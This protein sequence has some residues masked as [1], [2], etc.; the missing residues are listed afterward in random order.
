MIL[1]ETDNAPFN[2][3][4]QPLPP[5]IAPSQ[6]TDDSKEI[7][8]IIRVFHVAAT[9]LK[10]TPSDAQLTFL[11]SQIET[12]NSLREKHPERESELSQLLFNVLALAQQQESTFVKQTLKSLCLTTFPKF[13]RRTKKQP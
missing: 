1:N 11:R 9:C 12:L 6:K 5:K 10:K 4:F 13:P 2:G 7:P 8:L 3:R